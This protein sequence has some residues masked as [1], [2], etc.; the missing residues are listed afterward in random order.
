V[1]DTVGGPAVA[2]LCR[3]V[4]PRGA[5]VTVSTTPIDPE[6]LPTPPTFFAYRPD[7]ARLAR[8]VDGVAKG[9]ASMPV[10]RRLPFTSAAEAHRLM[11]AGGLAG[12]IVL[13][14]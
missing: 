4:A 7:G 6:G 1:A 13:E 14:P 11:E 3:D 8:I 10:A 12:K 2:K 9:L 5:I